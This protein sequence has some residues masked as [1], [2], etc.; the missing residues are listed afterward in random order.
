MATENR[1]KLQTLYTQLPAGTVLTPQDLSALGIS[2]DLTVHYA[3]A[4]WLRRLA[5]GVYVRP[6]DHLEVHG[7]LAMLQKKIPGLHVGGK[8]ALDWQGTRQYVEQNPTLRLYGSESAKLPDWF[9]SRFPASYHRKRLFREAPDHLLHVKP[10]QGTDAL[11]STP[12][13]ALLELLSEVGV[14][15]PLQEAREIMEAT[16]T[17]RSKVL[18]E[19]LL[20]CTSVK[21]VRLCLQLGHELSLPWAS[22]LDDA[23]LPTGGKSAWVARTGEGVLVLR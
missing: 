8:S 10:H 1:K 23:S 12:E 7:C 6:A 11:V 13:R 14:R 16:H 21:T 17:F 5:H 4:G 18:R 19:L 2:A 3:K 9:T 20:H 22:R 15:Q